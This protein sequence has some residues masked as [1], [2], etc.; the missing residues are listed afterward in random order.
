LPGKIFWVR[1]DVNTGLISNV[2]VFF[3]HANSSHVVNHFF[4]HLAS[5]FHMNT[6][7][8]NHFHC[9]HHTFCSLRTEFWHQ[10]S[11]TESFLPI[12]QF[13]KLHCIVDSLLHNIFCNKRRVLPT[14]MGHSHGFYPTFITVPATAFSIHLEYTFHAILFL[15]VFFYFLFCKRSVSNKSLHLRRSLGRLFFIGPSYIGRARWLSYHGPFVISTGWLLQHHPSLFMLDRRCE[16]IWLLLSCLTTFHRSM[17]LFHV[18]VVFMKH[19]LIVQVLI[20]FVL[21]FFTYLTAVN[22]WD[23]FLGHFV[24]INKFFFLFLADAW[25][26]SLFI[27]FVFT[28]FLAWKR[29]QWF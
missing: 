28:L 29:W 14:V 13:K 15:L 22:A 27:G 4:F 26:H 6:R 3:H 7:S 5:S 2:S 19:I 23:V 8:I 18:V 9:R 1:T 10:V 17:N 16:F 25:I 21:L 24:K 12:F 11:D 20:V